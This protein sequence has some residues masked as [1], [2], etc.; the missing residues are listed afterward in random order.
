M[1]GV[2]MS[3]DAVR[4]FMLEL[5][6][7][8]DRLDLTDEEIASVTE[9]H[10]DKAYWEEIQ[11]L[12]AAEDRARQSAGSRRYF[13]DKMRE[14]LV[15][16]FVTKHGQKD[17]RDE[18]NKAESLI[19]VYIQ[20]DEREALQSF[21]N[22][23]EQ[24]GCKGA[25]AKRKKDQA[26]RGYVGHAWTAL[27]GL[28]RLAVVVGV[29]SVATSRFETIVFALLILIYNSVESNFGI[30][31]MFWLREAMDME[32][33]FKKVRRLLKED[34]PQDER[35]AMFEKEQREGKDWSRQT[36]RSL[37]HYVFLFLTWAIALWE[38]GAAILG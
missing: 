32:A 13:Q 5:N 31:R 21:L 2:V 14:K 26:A 9:K 22:D 3:D 34:L 38:L 30:Y 4:D 20:T 33:N 29:F 6:R 10:W 24:L 12:L 11:G 19:T 36:T 15:I 35:E 37:I 17:D 8:V 23:V 25:N 7:R 27:V 18:R 16:D 28:V 1:G